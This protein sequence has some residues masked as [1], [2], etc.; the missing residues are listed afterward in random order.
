MQVSLPRFQ[1][2]P[3]SGPPTFL[4]HV[5]HLFILWLRHGRSFVISDVLQLH[6]N[7]LGCI[8]TTTAFC[9]TGTLLFESVLNLLEPLLLRLNVVGPCH[10]HSGPQVWRFNRERERHGDSSAMLMSAT[11]LVDSALKRPAAPP[12]QYCECS[13]RSRL[14]ITR[15]STPSHAQCNRVAALDPDQAA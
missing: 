7:P 11:Q 4:F 6:V 14:A 3:L 13:R 9:N 8:S 15:L 2:S 5:L 10:N 1:G 12:S